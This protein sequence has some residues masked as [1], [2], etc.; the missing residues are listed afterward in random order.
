MSSIFICHSSSDKRFVSTLKSRLERFGVRVWVD[1]DEI[2]AGV[3]LIGSIALAIE[4][5]DYLGVVLSPRSIRSKWVKEELELA[6]NNQIRNHI[7]D[8][9]VRVIPLLLRR[10]QIPGFLKG[11]KYIDFSSWG[12]LTKQRDAYEQLDQAV[13]QVV[14]AVG[15][16]PQDSE[17]W[18]GRSLIKVCDLRARIVRHF[19]PR[20]VTVHLFDDGSGI[21]F[22]KVDND[23][24]TFDLFELWSKPSYIEV[25]NEVFTSPNEPPIVDISVPDTGP[26]AKDGETV[27]AVNGICQRHG[28]ARELFPQSLT[29]GHEMYE[30]WILSRADYE[31]WLLQQTLVSLVR[32]GNSGSRERLDKMTDPHPFAHE[33]VLLDL[34]VPLGVIGGVTA[35]GGYSCILKSDYPNVAVLIDNDSIDLTF[36]PDPELLRELKQIYMLKQASAIVLP[37]QAILTSLSKR[38]NR[39]DFSSLR[40]Q[41]TS[42]HSDL[43]CPSIDLTYGTGDDYCE[44]EIYPTLTERAVNRTM[45]C[46]VVIED[47]DFVGE[48]AGLILSAGMKGLVNAG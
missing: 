45:S 30:R 33:A 32:A 23:D 21:E 1:E 36:D 16:D 2:R 34:F 25:L 43:P 38:F 37:Y 31:D 35:Y 9:R 4:E 28:L 12:L 27:E 48:L 11:E 15:I 22:I 44:I 46:R 26:W 3:S 5:M 6:L 18:S 19:A 8:S 41:I 29:A 39:T 40:I 20:P 14:R 7:R 10:C 47:P 42:L 13:K 17:R 24:D